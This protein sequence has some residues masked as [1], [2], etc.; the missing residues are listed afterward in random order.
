MVDL[1][2]NTV[3]ENR[4]MSEVTP[5]EI[6]LKLDTPPVLHEIAA[7]LR[8]GTS[9]ELVDWLGKRLQFASK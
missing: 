9:Y 4:Q 5:K 3:R 8:F 1:I 2:P 7:I 6:L